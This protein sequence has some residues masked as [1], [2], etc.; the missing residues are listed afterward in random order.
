MS[1][2]KMKVFLVNEI[3]SAIFKE[4]LVDKWNFNSI[5]ERE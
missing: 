4:P 5:T 3:E 1:D 2:L